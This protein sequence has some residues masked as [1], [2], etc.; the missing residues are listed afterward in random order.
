[1]NLEPNFNNSILAALSNYQLPADDEYLP[2]L[3]TNQATVNLK[4]HLEQELQNCTGFTLAVAF[5]TNGVL[6]DLKVQ[7]ADLASQNITG[8]ILTSTYLYFNQPHVFEELLKIPNVEVRII[9][10]QQNFHAKAYLF[11][12]PEGYQ[13]FILGSANL[14]EAALIQN[15]EWNIKLT[16]QRHG[17]L[18]RTINREIEQLWQT[19]QPLNKTWLD[20]YK[21][22]YRQ[23]APRFGSTKLPTLIA[24][25]IT[26]NT[27]QKDAL[28]SLTELRQSGAKRGLIVSATGT[29]KTYLGAFDVRNFNPRKFLFVVHREQILRK[30]LRSFRK[31][32]GGPA[33]DY[34]ILSGNQHDTDYKYLFATI[35]TLSRE[36][37]LQSLPA[38][39]F[40]Y[41]LIDEAHKAGAPTYQ[42]VIDHFQPEFLLG[43]T[44]TPERTD[45]FN[46]YEL[47]DYHIAYE[48]RLQAA[49][50]SDM[51]SQF[52]YV[53]ITDYE[54]QGQLID[55]KTPLRHLL[56]QERM[57]YVAKQIDYYG[58]DG[59]RVYG[60]IF[61]SRQAE[62]AEVAQ[63][64]TAKGHPA[65]ALTGNTSVSEREKIIRR[66]EKGELEYLVTVDIFNEGVDIPKVNQVIMLRNTESSIIFIQQLGR[67]LRKAPG[68]SFV[69]IIDFI[70]NYKNNYL[71]PIALT[72]DQ[73]LNKNRLRQQIATNQTIGLSS[74]NFSRIA[75]ERIYQSINHSN[76][77]LLATL[78]EAY[79]ALKNK[80]GRVPRLADFQKFGS[81]DGQVLVDKY[82]NYQQFLIKMHDE[83]PLT[84][85]A[86]AFLRLIS[87]EFLNGMRIHE[88]VLLQQL[89]KQPRYAKQALVNQL[90]ELGTYTDPATLQS[91]NNHLD[92]S[93][94]QPRD[95][96]KYGQTAWVTLQDGYY[97]LNDELWAQYQQNPYFKDLVDDVLQ[98]GM[99]NSKRYDQQTKFTRNQRYTRRHVNRLLGWP[100]DQ[101][102][103]IYGYKANQGSCPLFVI[104]QKRPQSPVAARHQNVFYDTQTLSWFTKTPRKLDSKEVVH[105]LK[106]NRQQTIAFPL[107]VKKSEDEGADFYYLGLVD[108]DFQSLEQQTR[109]IN[110]HEKPIVKA[111]LQLRT[112]V[113]YQLYLNLIN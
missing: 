59:E 43:M 93:Y 44:A 91:V 75:K 5:I 24:P 26:P 60:L 66:F 62:A 94:F 57:D 64:M 28:A 71:I 80:L 105:L 19:A 76:L 106:G 18:A 40:D 29:G 112:P 52:H 101:S 110:G 33:S 22:A 81:V 13:T 98:V 25:T 49:I 100:K 103:A 16:A 99:W 9:D 86:D 27:M 37:V 1:M 73:S 54:Y 83:Q 8:R 90:H 17:Q 55:E 50:E 20:Q 65:L 7:F 77:T 82:E 89:F 10:Q 70:G 35:Q 74:I 63:I 79:Q 15:Y 111:N 4:L 3:I 96:V 45:D 84:K 6:T 30:S 14:T 34:G 87:R 95:Q 53:G 72:G 47:F 2:Q 78:R 48:I 102:S 39:T 21:E 36:S 109:I 12:K 58:H 42:R 107:F 104:Y 67:G 97:Q 41:V 108:F 32:L 31:V 51:L 11:D 88:L 69:T 68:K 38:D 113:D 46:I 23:A 92:L 61:C 85:S 56:A